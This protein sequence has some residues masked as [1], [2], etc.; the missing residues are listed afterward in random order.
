MNFDLFQ[1]DSFTSD[2]FRGNPACIVPLK[3]WLPDEIS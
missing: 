1:I 2:I 3:R